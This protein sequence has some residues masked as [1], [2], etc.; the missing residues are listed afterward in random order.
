MLV[1]LVMV[2]TATQSWAGSKVNIGLM[3]ILA[4]NQKGSV[5]PRLKNV[6][7]ELQSVFKYSSYELIG[8]EQMQLGLKQTGTA[9]LPGK[10]VLKVT[11]HRITGDRVEM[12]LVIIR[13][14]KK[15][16]QTVVSLL[17]GGSI[18]VGGPKHKGGYLLFK[19]SGS[20]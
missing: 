4:S 20:Y 16:F 7:G 1:A 19:I 9:P 11:P 5:D 17:N 12:R 6:V 15:L 18:F 8:T 3:T 13:K 14:K 2:S 10:R